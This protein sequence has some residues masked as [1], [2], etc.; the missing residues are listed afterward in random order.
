L[1]TTMGL[2]VP[3]LW[4]L[5]LFLAVS[6]AASRVVLGVHFLTD[7]LAGSLLGALAGATAFVTVLR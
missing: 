2:A 3:A 5:L 7:A 1:A 6:I 4:P